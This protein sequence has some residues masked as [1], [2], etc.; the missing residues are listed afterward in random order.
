[1]QDTIKNFTTYIPTVTMNIPNYDENQR[2]IETT[3]ESLINK[4]LKFV[5]NSFAMENFEYVTNE[6]GNEKIAEIYSLLGPLDFSNY[7]EPK[8]DDSPR[9]DTGSRATGSDF[10][11]LEERR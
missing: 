9:G 11:D 3:L 6:L 10:D 8:D 5:E 4:D 2:K 7:V 1:M